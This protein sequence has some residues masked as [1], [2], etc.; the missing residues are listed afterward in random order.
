MTFNA[1]F[2]ATTTPPEP[3]RPPTTTASGRMRGPWRTVASRVHLSNVKRDSS[4]SNAIAPSVDSNEG[5]REL[6]YN[7]TRRHSTLG[8]LSPVQF[9]KMDG[10]RIKE[11]KNN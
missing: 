7:A 6:F 2:T 10:Q 8:M 3:K 5:V 1:A 9:E 4:R 11:A